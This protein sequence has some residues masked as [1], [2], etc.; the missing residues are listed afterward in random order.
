M[1]TV[2]FDLDDASTIRTKYP[3]IR[4]LIG[5][6]PN[7][8]ISLFWIP[9]DMEME[10]GQLVRIYHD[11]RLKEMHELMKTGNIEL[12]PHGLTHFSHEFLN[13]DKY[14][15]K[16]YM[17][18][19]E[20]QMVRDGLPYVKG[21]KAPFW[22][23]NQN[24]VD[25]LDEEG[26]FIATD[27]NQP[28]SLKT[29]KY[30]EFN[31]SIHEPFWLSDNPLWKLHGHMLGSENDFEEHFLNLYKIPLDAEFKFVSELLEERKDE[32]TN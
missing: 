3:L 2:A 14:T 27:R 21:F 7:I 19:V 13:A 29:K 18:A 11:D 4:Q 22:E 9:F 26:W 10:M 25:A 1:K 16:V 30:Y 17:K 8:K 28:D 5:R 32:K 24:V 6:Y 20:E 31:Y 15:V 23:Y 12:I